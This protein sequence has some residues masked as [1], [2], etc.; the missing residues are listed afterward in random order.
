MFVIG[1]L[2]GIL[3]HIIHLVEH[4]G[5]EWNNKIN[6]RDYMNNKIEKAKEYENLKI[7]SMKNNENCV[8]N[9]HKSKEQFIRLVREPGWFPH[10]SCIFSG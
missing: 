1:E 6:F 8:P 4:N 10:K 3:T 2:D 9:Y 5:N 7:N